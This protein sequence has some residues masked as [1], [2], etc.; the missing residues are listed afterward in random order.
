VVEARGSTS[1]GASI[2]TSVRPS[3]SLYV[4]RFFPAPV[5][6]DRAGQRVFVA[7]ELGPVFLLSTRDESP[8]VGE[9]AFAVAQAL[10]AVFSTA[11]LPL[12]IREG[13]APAVASGGRVLLRATP[14]DAAGYVPPWAPAMKT[15]RVTPRALAG[16]WLA[17]LQDMHGLFVER[18]R[19][20]K[21]VEISPRGRVLLELYAE[22]ARMTAGGVPTSLVNPLPFTVGKAFRE[23]TLTPSQGQG[24]ASAAVTGNWEGTVSEQGHPEQEVKLSLRVEGG[25]LAGLFRTAA[26]A[27]AMETPITQA[28]F[29]KGVLT[30]GLS[31]GGETRRFRGTLSGAGL[32]GTIESPGKGNVGQFTLRYVE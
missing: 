1:S 18:Q 31:R 12:E 32:S 4:P 13:A 17:L 25:K 7:S 3:S 24:T 29:D 20:V 6:E 22:G 15:G 2:F 8:S 9:R 21:V 16:Y 14:D 27:I 5:E 28:T 23:M 11:T 10:N 19:P 30:F 26:G